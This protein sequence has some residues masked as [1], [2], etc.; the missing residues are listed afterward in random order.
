MKDASYLL[1]DPAACRTV[2][3][4]NVCFDENIFYRM[5]NS[6]MSLLVELYN[7]HIQAWKPTS[8]LIVVTEPKQDPRNDS[9]ILVPEITI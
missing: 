4:H 5:P 9:D 7:E 8:T 3:S 1:W 6:M 2:Q